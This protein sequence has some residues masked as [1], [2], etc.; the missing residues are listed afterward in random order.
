MEAHVAAGHRVR[1]A[2]VFD[3]M[4]H[5]SH[6]NVILEN[7]LR[8][9]LH[10]A[11]ALLAL[12]AGPAAFH[13]V[14]VGPAPPAPPTAVSRLCTSTQVAAFCVILAQVESGWIQLP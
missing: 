11:S 2:A 12:P 5:R 7:F 8:P 6:A 1:V 4:T 3:V 14:K 13:R 9:Y 10:R